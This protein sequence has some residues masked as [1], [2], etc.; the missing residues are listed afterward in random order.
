MPLVSLNAEQYQKK[1]RYNTDNKTK[2]NCVIL[3][4]L[5]CLVLLTLK[6]INCNLKGANCCRKLLHFLLP[7]RVVL[8]VVGVQGL[9]K[10]MHSQLPTFIQYRT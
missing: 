6:I 10:P 5:P 8:V 7:N 9:S 2:C 4:L 1:C 3:P